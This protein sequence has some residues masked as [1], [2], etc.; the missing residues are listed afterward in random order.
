MCGSRVA[1]ADSCICSSCGH[2]NVGIRTYKWL[3]TVSSVV[4]STKQKKIGG[5][6]EQAGVGEKNC[7]QMKPNTVFSHES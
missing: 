1:S 6:G 5:S 2:L 4:K 3:Q 7:Q